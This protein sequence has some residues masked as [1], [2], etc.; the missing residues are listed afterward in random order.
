MISWLQSLT[1]LE[2]SGTIIFILIV[3]LII[4]IALMVI[5]HRSYL[6]ENTI[7]IISWIA[8]VILVVAAFGLIIFVADNSPL[9][10]ATYR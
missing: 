8:N 4:R 7:R 1:L 5:L 2:D 9:Y 6:Q 10:V 3:L